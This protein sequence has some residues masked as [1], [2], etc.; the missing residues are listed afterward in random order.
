M[1]HGSVP[2]LCRDL[3][4]D[5]ASGRGSRHLDESDDVRHAARL[6]VRLL[7]ALSVAAA[8]A[9]GI[10]SDLR[11][12]S[13][14]SIEARLGCHRAIE[15]VY[16]R[17]RSWPAE[18]RS[19]KPSLT[20]VVS[21]TRLR[22]QVE[23]GLAKSNALKR[24]WNYD[25]SPERLQGEI[26]RMA[27]DSRD[28]GTLRE[29]FDALGND[30]T[31]IAECLVRPI[32]ADQK[33]RNW[34]A[35]DQRVHGEQ[36][37][38]IERELAVHTASGD[39]KRLSGAYAELSIESL[40]ADTEGER[41]LLAAAGTRGAR[42]RLQ[43]TDEAYFVAAQMEP[44]RGRGRTAVVTWQKKA[45]D[46][47]WSSARAS[48]EATVE[49]SARDLYVPQVGSSS[50]TP[51]SWAPTSVLPALAGHKAV[52]TGTEMIV[53]GAMNLFPS[54]SKG[55]GVRYNPVTDSWRPI[56]PGGPDLPD[57]VVWTGSQAIVWNGLPNSAG[58][59]YDPATDLWTPISA[60]HAPSGRVDASAVW[61]G[62]EMI[63]WGGNSPSASI[64]F[65]PVN[66]GGRYNPHTDSWTPTSTTDAPTGRSSHG[67]IWTGS[68]MVV[69]GGKTSAFSTTDTGGRYDPVAD[70]WTATST[71]GA[72]TGQ[73]GPRMVWTGS[74]M[75]VWGGAGS[76]SNTP[77][78]DVFSGG[79]YNPLTDAWT[80]ITTAN[81]PAGRSQH[82]VVWTGSE[83][84]VGGGESATLGELATGGRYNPALNQ[85]VA[86]STSNA[87]LHRI[88]HTAVW[89]GTEMIIWGGFSQG[90][91]S[92]STGGRYAPG[93][94]SWT[95]TSGVPAPFA[96]D[97]HTATWTG[98]E[99]IVWGGRNSS[100][101]VSVT[102]SGAA[103]IPATDS[104]V[105]LPTD[106]A[107]AARNAHRAVWTGT[108]VVVFG[109]LG[110]SGLAPGGG[111]YRPVAGTWLPMSTVSA[112]SN[113]IAFSIVWTGTH[114]FVWGGATGTFGPFLNTGG[115][116]DPSGDAWTSTSTSGAV[117]APTWAVPAFWISGRVVLWTQGG[118]RYDPVADTWSFVS[119]VGGPGGFPV[120]PSVV[121]TG[122]EMFVLQPGGYPSARYNP[123]SDTWA[124]VSMIGAPPLLSS[125]AIA[126]TGSQI[127]LW[128][129]DRT[130]G[131][132]GARYSPASNSWQP[133]RASVHAPARKEGFTTTWTGTEMILWGGY[134]WTSDGT[135]ATLT[136]WG[137]AY[138]AG[139]V[140][141]PSIGSLVVNFGS[142]H[143]I[144]RYSQG[145]WTLLHALSPEAMTKGDLDGN[146]AE[147]LVFDFGPG[148]GVWAWM[149]DATWASV[150]TLS[151]V[152]MVLG[153]LDGN[154]QDDL[155]LEFA[156]YGVWVRRNMTTW[157]LLHGAATN[158]LVAGN[159]DGI[160]GDDLIVDLPGYGLWMFANNASWSPFHSANATVLHVANIDGT[161]TDDVVVGFASYGLW[162]Y[163][164]HAVWA[165][166]FPR[167]TTTLASGDADG[168]GQADLV[169]DLGADGIWMWQNNATWVALHWL[170]AQDIVLADLDGN[171]RDDIAVDFG[172]PHG[173]WIRSDNATWTPLHGFSPVGL[174]AGR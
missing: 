166:L 129:T 75:I 135:V 19:P 67:A 101:G 35:G 26:D 3:S 169:I 123:V 27:R 85:W 14:L 54:G 5:L 116:Y 38:A 51:D 136:D 64:P 139:P 106:G 56:A 77:D 82:S 65:L 70:T 142:P 88:Y 170:S 164:N 173:L 112:P 94:N 33:L 151:P 110:A 137:T 105:A 148:V 60:V 29:L 50:C 9:A 6:A 18:N 66:T 73:D 99:M 55:V 39:M 10:H 46:D 168:N 172:A 132:T 119:A 157:A 154:G 143:G 68:R 102:N 24:L 22:Q 147:D 90:S 2:G 121:S 78:G 161:G 149:N 58:A 30:S 93:S 158:H 130:S 53:F 59:R 28:P 114:V 171:G 80:P 127:L 21:D 122:A 69:W 92:L 103:Y 95:P 138:C 115:R 34:F 165:P 167:T 31:L 81:A 174:L 40:R 107:P 118:R 98:A 83:F 86:T 84:V 12:D 117:P 108:D 1:T 111:R 87:P 37:A 131:G 113:R 16:W 32:A 133:M 155:V 25:L 145:A 125:R 141:P 15:E 97:A 17:H 45:F 104:W 71:A 4:G 13:S 61:T 150:H 74:E 120:V 140:D 144:Y 152:R 153:D 96:R 89:T 162:T 63:L 57:A 52:W 23:E 20:T 159:L 160:G 76:L 126:W 41:V 43:E 91:S 48:F 100:N 44:A 62:Q 8:G 72:A 163:R 36:R 124:P 134:D 128:T 146:G 156:G 109:G 49:P 7:A 47:W 42:G 11:A 79:R